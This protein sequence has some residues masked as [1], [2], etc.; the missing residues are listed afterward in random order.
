MATVRNRKSDHSCKHFCVKCRSHGTQDLSLDTTHL[1]IPITDANP[2]GNTYENTPS[3]SSNASTTIIEKP[4][5]Y[6]HRILSSTLKHDHSNMSLKRHSRCD[7]L[8]N[9]TQMIN[10][11]YMMSMSKVL[12]QMQKQI[13]KLKRRTNRVEHVF[14]KQVKSVQPIIRIPRLTKDQLTNVSI[15]NDDDDDDNDDIL[16]DTETIPDNNNNN[17]KLSSNTKKNLK[18]LNKHKQSKKSRST[19]W[20]NNRQKPVDLNKYC[21]SCRHEF[22]RRSNFL[23][24]IRNIHK[25]VIPTII[26]ERN[27][28]LLEINEGN[29]EKNFNENITDDSQCET[30][31]DQLVDQSGT[32]DN[33]LYRRTV[34]KSIYEPQ[35]HEKVKCDICNKL[36]R[37]TYM[38]VHK[39]RAHSDEEFLSTSNE[40][41]NN[42]EHCDSVS[43]KGNDQEALSN[44]NSTPIGALDIQNINTPAAITIADMDTDDEPIRFCT[45]MTRPIVI[46]VTCLESYQLSLVE[47]FLEK[48]SSHVCQT[49]S[50][51]SRTT[52]LITNDDKHSLRSPLSMKLIEAIAHHCFCVSY[53]WIIDCLKYDRIIEEESYEIEGDDTDVHPHGGP[54][55]SRLIKNQHSLFQNICFMI[56]C[57]ENPD[58]RMTNERLEDLITTCGGQIIT[59]VTQRLLDR[60]QI[61][62][63][64]DMLYVSER[65]HNYDQCRSL[66][67]HFVSSDW[68]GDSEITTS[69][70]SQGGRLIAHLY[71]TFKIMNYQFQTSSPY[72]HAAMSQAVQSILNGGPLPPN[73]LVMSVP[74]QQVQQ[75][76]PPFMMKPPFGDIDPK[77]FPQQIPYYN[78]SPY[79]NNS[80]AR[81]IMP[82]QNYN[83]PLATY[84]NNA[85]INNKKSKKTNHQQPHANVY[86]SAS[87]DSYMRHLSWSRL[88]DHSS[89][90]TFKQQN[91][92]EAPINYEKGSN[93]S[94]NQRLNSSSSSSSTTSDETIRQVNVSNKQ[95]SNIDPKQQTKGTLPFKYSSEFVPGVGKQQQ[96]QNIKP[97]DVF[98]VK[99]P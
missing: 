97:N 84:K 29:I 34:T 9:Y 59:C 78:L 65:R 93:S 45:D 5:E 24:H 70:H 41:N 36:Y 71:A 48:F 76:L 30:T 58:I 31:N 55:R 17:I 46:A 73:C 39:R 14:I 77:V 23:M 60:Y 56:K 2:T 86:N 32:S 25:G 51:D 28:S 11:K 83:Y 63:L 20:I 40:I 79:L 68:I 54:R 75:M 85:N 44:E 26:N 27:Q 52:H 81:A 4:S 22:S 33:R 6:G 67:I 90:K 8:F 43:D 13:Y 66:G 57:T 94:K 98:I 49:T 10:R 21:S 3:P 50:I 62:V 16:D 69:S 96:S 18:R 19:I 95:S 47:Q 88:F 53:R 12:F 15:H 82:Q 61:I 42:V 38:K 35:V 72:V 74:F 99:K 87:F 89:R 92:D 80:Q 1:S 91:H 64:C 7:K 37:L